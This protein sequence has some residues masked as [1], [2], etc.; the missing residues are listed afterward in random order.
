MIKLSDMIEKMGKGTYILFTCRYFEGDDD[1]YTIT[2]TMSAKNRGPGYIIPPTKPMVES[3]V[4]PGRK[5]YDL[6]T[7]QPPGPDLSKL[8]RVIIKEDKNEPKIDS[9][10]QSDIDW[11]VLEVWLHS[12]GFNFDKRG[13]RYFSNNFHLLRSIFDRMD[14]NKDDMIDLDDI[15]RVEIVEKDSDEKR[16]NYFERISIGKRLLF[17]LPSVL[18]KLC[19]DNKSNNFQMERFPFYES[20]IKAVKYSM[21]ENRILHPPKE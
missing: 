15:I 7:V 14:Y 1:Q 9:F 20:I 10:K 11:L 3:S 4:M 5:L 6:S 18:I 21:N 13:D 8:R 2:K 12:N 17:K 16:N 19:G